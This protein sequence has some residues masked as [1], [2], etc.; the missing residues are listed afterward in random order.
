MNKAIS[1]QQLGI[2]FVGF[3]MTAVLLVVAAIF[4][5]K[6]IPTYMESGKIQKAF[7]A[8]VHDPAMRSASVAEIKNSYY[9]RAIAMDDVKSVMPDDIVISKDGGRFTLSASYSAKVKLAGNVSLLLEFN[10]SASN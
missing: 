3:I 1:R 2:T 10:P 4:A 7:E 8:M 9:K 6:L 5:M